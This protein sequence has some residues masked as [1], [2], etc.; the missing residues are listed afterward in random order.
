MNSLRF[1]TELLPVLYSSL[2]LLLTIC[3]S[4][5]KSNKNSESETSGVAVLLIDTDHPLST[6]DKNIYGDF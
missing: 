2:S 1:E 4:E 5:N 3:S 6:I